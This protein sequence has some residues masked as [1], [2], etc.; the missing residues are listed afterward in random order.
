M[1]RKDSVLEY[2]S[3]EENLAEAG[4][5]ENLKAWLEKRRQAF[6]P[7]ARQFGIDS[8]RGI[9]LLGVQGCGKTMV[10]R[11]VAREWGLPLL[12]ME[13]ART[14]RAAMPT[15]ASPSACSAG[16]SPGCRI[17]RPPS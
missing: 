8:P 16:C 6:A 5:F 3:P 9:L 10:A 15:P 4:G 13:P 1:L 14:T 11:A 7:E 2:V 17:G 12:K